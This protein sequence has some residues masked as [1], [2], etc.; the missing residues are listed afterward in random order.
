MVR[1]VSMGV[2][3]VILG[4]AMRA[5]RARRGSTPLTINLSTRWR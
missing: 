4:Y 1:K 2:Y 3:G 5:H